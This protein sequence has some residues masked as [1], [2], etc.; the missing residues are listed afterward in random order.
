VLAILW[1][2]MARNRPA[3]LAV[4]PLEMTLTDRGGQLVVEWNRSRPE[5]R[6]VRSGEISIVDGGTRVR[7]PLTAGEAQIGSFT[8]VP[9]SGD[10]QVLLRLE[11]HGKPLSAFARFLGPPPNQPAPRPAP[12]PDTADLD[13]L[14]KENA[15][16]RGE[17]FRAKA[18]A[19]QAE[20]A[21][22]V[23]RERLNAAE[24][25]K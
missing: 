3:E 10:V 7:L 5:L 2:Y 13:R 23:L 19:D 8:F 18:R 16:L 15:E 24:S 21:I 12:P 17:V 20:T 4:I 11:G 25:K 6:L 22:R 14:R 9:K 1:L